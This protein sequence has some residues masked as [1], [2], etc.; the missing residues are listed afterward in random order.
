MTSSKMRTAPCS[1]ARITQALQEARAPGRRRP[2]FPR[3]GG[4]IS[5]T[6]WSLFHARES[7]TASISLYGST[8][9]R[10]PHPSVTPRREGMYKA[11]RG[12]SPPATG[13]AAGVAVVI[14]IELDELLAP[15]DC[16]A[17][18]A[19]GAHGCFVL[20]LTMRTVFWTI[21]EQASR[22]SRP[23]PWSA[24]RSWCPCRAARAPRP[25][26][27]QERGPGSSDPSWPRSRYTALPSA[28]QTREPFARSYKIGSV[29][30]AFEDTGQFVDATR[31]HVLGDREELRKT[32]CHAW[33]FRPPSDHGVSDGVTRATSGGSMRGIPVRGVFLTAAAAKRLIVTFL[34][35][36][37]ACSN[38]S[39]LV[40]IDA[41]K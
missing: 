3:S 6:A 16:S 19:D 11:S 25:S 21:F 36:A 27:H 26:R 34:W 41:A 9:V 2:V 37:A 29:Q 32:W 23:R 39:G 14:P 4:T 13:G 18:E 5:S 15:G 10:P 1:C 30:T 24:R 38:S 7:R 31:D 22:P 12:R 8:M 17:R 40:A 33:V 35:H 20:P 28:S